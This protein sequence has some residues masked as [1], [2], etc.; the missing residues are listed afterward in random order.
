MGPLKYTRD[1]FEYES[2]ENKLINPEIHYISL[3]TVT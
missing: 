1:N 3:T 2:I